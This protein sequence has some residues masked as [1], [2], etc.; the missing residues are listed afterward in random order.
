MPLR[1]WALRTSQ[2]FALMLSTIMNPS[3][4]LSQRGLKPLHPFTLPFL[5][6]RVIY[7]L[8]PSTQ[9]P[10]NRNT[11]LIFILRGP[12]SPR[13]SRFLHDDQRISFFFYYTG[14][15]LFN[16]SCRWYCSFPWPFGDS[17]RSLTN[18]FDFHFL[19]FLVIILHHSSCLRRSPLSGSSLPD[20]NT[21]LP[22]A[23]LAV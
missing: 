13:S 16:S 6:R 14:G 22:S 2:L 11:S 17:S 18:P 23:Y 8:K 1:S 15:D 20:L 10:I 3:N 12:L 19:L 21:R 7:L 9:P 4:R 5:C